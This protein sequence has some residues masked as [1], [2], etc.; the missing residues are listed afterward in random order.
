MTT[1]SDEPLVDANALTVAFEPHGPNARIV[2]FTDLSFSVKPSE[3]IVVAGRS[4]S[5]KTSLLN[6]VAGIS[7]P[8]S[9]EVRWRGESLSGM[10]ADQLATRRATFIGYVF[11]NAGLID[12]LTA[13]E[14]VSLSAIPTKGTRS[15]ESRAGDL[16]AEFGLAGRANHF[17]PQLSGGE[18][19]R[20]A[21]A[22]ALH[23]NPDVLVVDEPTANADRATATALIGY[24]RRLAEE[25]RGLVVAS[26]DPALIA[27]ADRTI[28]IEA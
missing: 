2:L 13:V 17:P 12:T 7:R 9:G 28:E 5:G 8:T 4:G 26:H 18:Q 1:F 14:N 15:N 6:V 19:Q 22:R 27:V 20:V 16:L 11:Q 24:L 10:T 25:G 23:S 21:I 3:L